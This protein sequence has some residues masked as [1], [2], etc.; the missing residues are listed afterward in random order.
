MSVDRFAGR[1]VIVTGGAS[2]QGE[3]ECRRLA[4]EGA[5][6]VVADVSDD[7]GRR[8]ADELAAVGSA[9]FVHLDVSSRDGW[10]RLRDHL[11]DTDREVRGLVNNAG[12]GVPGRLHDV[13]DRDWE[14]AYA[15]NATGALLGIQLIAPIM[16]PGSAIV[17]IGS[18]ASLIA[19]HNIAYGAAKWALRGLTRSAAVELAAQK[20]RVNLVHPGFILTPINAGMDERFREAQLSMTP[21]RRAGNVAEVAEVVLFLLSDAASFV[22]GIELPVDGGFSA[23]GGSM[24]IFNALEK[25]DS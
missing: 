14:R 4:A 20:I 9:E 19:H 11:V 2:G 13:A 8:L 17:N 16:P 24:A 23:H 5:H 25:D 10:I 22:T 3:E 7:S 12:V 1:T 18:I 15:V 21:M 6:V